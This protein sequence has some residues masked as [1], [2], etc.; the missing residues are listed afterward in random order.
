M[1][2][3]ADAGFAG[4]TAVAC[5]SPEGL[6]V[7]FETALSMIASLA[8]AVSARRKSAHLRGPCTLAAGAVTRR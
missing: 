4:L 2:G 1:P 5:P 8:S 7:T 6:R 3:C